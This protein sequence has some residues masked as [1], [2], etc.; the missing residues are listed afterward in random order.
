MRTVSTTSGEMDAAQ[1]GAVN[2]HEHVILDGSGNPRIPEDFHHTDI[3]KIAPELAAWKAA[4]GGAIVDSSPIGAG[5]NIALLTQT[6]RDAGLPLIAA[7]GF[8]KHSY[9]PGDHWAFSEPEETL[10]TI[11]LDECTRGILLDDRSPFTSKRSEI[12]AGIL[13]MG[14][15]AQGVTPWLAKIIAATARTMEKTAVP[16]MFHTEPGVPFEALI[17]KLDQDHIPPHRTILCHMG[18]SLDPELHHMLAREGFYLEFDEMVRPAPPLPKLAR[19]IRQL[20]D[21]GR[22]HSVLFAGD[23]A[24]RS[25][26]TCYGGTPGLPYLMTKLPRELSSFGF[27]RE[28]LDEIWVKN[29]QR[30]FGGSPAAG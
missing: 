12:K 22:G 28:M 20:F 14:L 1:L 26:W 2:V 3:A 27:T 17:K 15:D 5:R 19:A 13:K 21:R 16:C 9:Y 7:T 8:H 30:L 4:G 24:R 6:S 23:L 25:Y 11:L 18:K 10:H 29:P